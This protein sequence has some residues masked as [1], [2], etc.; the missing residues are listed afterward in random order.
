MKSI[1]NEIYTCISW[2]NKSG[3]FPMKN[4]DVI[5][6]QA[7]C[8]VIYIFLGSSLSITVPSFIIVGYVW[9]ILGRGPFCHP[10]SH[11]WEAPKRPI[12]KRVKRY[13]NQWHFYPQAEAESLFLI[14]LKII[15]QRLW[16]RCFPVNFAKFLQTPF[17]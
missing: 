2:Y 13:Q 1:S 5:R 17:L 12:V 9:Q 4:S 16:H 15:K 14:K 11:P 3:W 7:M 10:L 6:T 8:R